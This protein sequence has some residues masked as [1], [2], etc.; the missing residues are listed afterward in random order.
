MAKAKTG[1]KAKLEMNLEASFSIVVPETNQP[2]FTKD[3]KRGELCINVDL[4]VGS[5]TFGMEVYPDHFSEGEAKIGR[6]EGEACAIDISGKVIKELDGKF[7]EDLIAEL[8]KSGSLPVKF[9]YISASGEWFYKDGDD[10]A[11]VKIG[12]ARLV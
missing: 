3:L 1:N 6:F 4:V 2:G 10:S 5:L 8:R 9:T 11:T 7:Y 12:V